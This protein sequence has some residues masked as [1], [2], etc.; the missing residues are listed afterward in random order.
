M[1]S[2]SISSLHIYGDHWDALSCVPGPQYFLCKARF[3]FKRNRL[4]CV[5][6]ANENHKK[7]K[8]LRWQAANRGCHSFDREFLYWVALAFVTWKFHATNASASQYECSVDSSCGWLLAWFSTQK[9]LTVWLDL[10][11]AVP[12]IWMGREGS[13][14]GRGWRKVKGHPSFANR[15]LQPPAVLIVSL[16]AGNCTPFAD[17]DVVYAII[18]D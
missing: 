14:A 6:C 2:E 10:R 3:P 17:T 13:R 7:R 15:S 8:R 4:R 16:L 18:I 1:E 12:G 11:G 9:R 5:R